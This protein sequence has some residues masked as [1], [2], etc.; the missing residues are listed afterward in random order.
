MTKIKVNKALHASLSALLVLVL[1]VTSLPLTSMNTSAETVSQTKYENITDFQNARWSEIQ[2]KVFGKDFG[3]E[4]QPIETIKDLTVQNSQDNTYFHWTDTSKMQG[5][6]NDGTEREGGLKKYDGTDTVTSMGY[7]DINEGYLQKFTKYDSINVPIPISVRKGYRCYN[8][9]T[10]DQFVYL[11]NYAANNGK[12]I[13]MVLQ[14]DIDMG[15][16]EGKEFTTGKQLLS[17]L[18]IEGNGHTIY[19]WKMSGS[20]DYFGLFCS[21]SNNIP[22]VSFATATLIVKNLGVQSAMLLH[23]TDAKESGAGLFLGGGWNNGGVL[24]DNVHMNGMFF[25]QDATGTGSGIGFMGGRGSYKNNLLVNNCSTSN[26]YMYGKGHLGGMFSYTQSRGRTLAKYDIKFPESPE[27]IVY[28]SPWTFKETGTDEKGKPKTI[29]WDPYPVFFNNCSSVDCE[30]F[31]TGDDSGAFVSCGSGILAVNCYTNNTM[32]S[33]GNTGGF[34]GRVG[35]N[36]S[37]RLKTSTVGDIEATDA[38]MYDDNGKPTIGCCFRNC[39]TAGVVEG[40]CAMGG[41]TGLDCGYRVS[42]HSDTQENAS[43]QYPNTTVY[44]NCY[45]TTMVGMDYAGKFC[46]GFTGLEDNYSRHVNWN[47]KEEDLTVK[48]DDFYGASVTASDGTK[49]ENIYGS[50]YMNCYAAGEVGN[51]LTASDTEKAVEYEKTFYSDGYYK[52]EENMENPQYYP[53]GGFIGA[54]NPDLYCLKTDIPPNISSIHMRV[55]LWR[56][57]PG[58]ENYTYGYFYNCYYDMQTS[59]MREMAVGLA[60]A[61]TCRDDPTG[62]NNRQGSSDDTKVIHKDAEGNEMP[63]SV[64]G[65]TGVYTEKS[66]VKNVAGL[67]GSPVE[68]KDGSGNVLSRMSMS[69]EGAVKEDDSNWQYN[70][71]YYPQ[72]KAFMSSD[73]TV[74]NI[75]DTQASDITNDVKSSAFYVGETEEAFLEID[76]YEYIT[77]PAT[78]P[79][80]SLVNS[81]EKIYENYQPNTN[82]YAAELAS[83]LIP[84]RYSQASTATVKL[85]HWDYK[86]NTTDG[87]LSTDN[88]WA[89]GVASNQLKL[90]SDTGYFENTYTGLS[91]GKYSFKVQANSSMTYNYGSNRFDGQNCELNIPVENCSA[92][93]MF[94]YNGLRSQ[95]YQIYAVLANANGE[96]IDENGAKT[97]D[98]DGN[99]VEKKILL[100]GTATDVNPD[101]WTLVGILPNSTW[102]VT[103]A[104]YDLK[105]SPTNSSIYTYTCDFTPNK[106]ESGNYV[107]TECQFK[108]AKD[109]AWTESYGIA[110]KSDNMS[111][112]YNQPCTVYFEFN[113]KTHIT[114]VK[115][116]SGE[117]YKVFTEKSTEYD[118]DGFSVIGQQSLTGYNWLESGKELEAATKGK[119]V[120]TESGSGIYR[121]SFDNVKMGANYAY[122][123]IENA[124]DSGGNSY[125]SI[126]S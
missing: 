28:M 48:I 86:M 37:S 73:T 114:T 60:Y 18:C 31:S 80:M 113:T 17:N 10:A 39:Y 93:I 111:F 8:V 78:H 40:K 79:V 66:D 123:V 25:Q 117:I 24:F 71:G 72:L 52:S 68:Y 119:L 76:G 115:A 42:D 54:I 103:D 106:D 50:V 4:V 64:I 46:G 70:D 55:D 57:M 59:G 14:A 92:R 1:L 44:S 36:L 99:P 49:I 126:K 21:S 35:H 15:G 125:F 95:D 75:N 69:G 74:G 34:I 98:Q 26:G 27:A 22:S 82:V 53:S 16:A 56:A 63:F 23:H 47:N 88:D 120:E 11:A 12:S 122:K 19:N 67:T 77:K 94:K 90:N 45:S 7:V 85:S 62:N 58:T 43:L 110:G 83:V 108:I 100:G 91:S 101:V 81:K 109:H 5:Y 124:V 30:L 121:V 20:S 3:G 29:S 116:T 32:Y 104:K 9:Y 102:N 105:I 118:F 6:N 84:Y 65:I 112:K 61:E 13:K 97:V 87:S 2:S 51:I 41:F 96:P 33:N 89:C 38:C 107:E